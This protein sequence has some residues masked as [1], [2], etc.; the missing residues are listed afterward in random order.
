M[1]VMNK[2]KKQIAILAAVVVAMFFGLAF[3]EDAHADEQ[4]VATQYGTEFT[5]LGDNLWSVKPIQPQ[6]ALHNI[7]SKQSWLCN[8]NNV[9]PGVSNCEVGKEYITNGETENIPNGMRSCVYIQGDD[10]A[11]DTVPNDPT[12][13]VCAIDEP[14]DDPTPEPT[15]TEPVIIPP[16]DPTPTPE[17]SNTDDEIVPNPGT[18]MDDGTT[19]HGQG[20]EPGHAETPV[21]D[22]TGRTDESVPTTEPSTQESVE[23][24]ATKKSTVASLN[25]ETNQ[26][27]HTGG[28]VWIPALIFFITLSLG[29]ALV[30]LKE[31]S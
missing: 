27:A 14:S 1:V 29:F 6:F 11:W 8:T 19:E 30:I 22:A 18:D 25:H 13:S 28:D 9:G 17:P 7:G 10:P 26:L 3:V 21:P 4:F 5:Y 2:F 31:R 12:K 15:K 16:V 20:G 23:Q 24:P